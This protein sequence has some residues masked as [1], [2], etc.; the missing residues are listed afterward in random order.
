MT[1]INEKQKQHMCPIH[2]FKYKEKTRNKGICKLEQPNTYDAASN[3]TKNKQ[4]NKNKKDENTNNKKKER[5]V[6]YSTNNIS[7][8]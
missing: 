8:F 7:L 3:K 2:Y 5:N 6:I 1:A 4:T